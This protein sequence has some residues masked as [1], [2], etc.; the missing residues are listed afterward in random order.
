[1]QTQKYAVNQYLIESVLAKVRENE[2]AIPEIQRPFVW[3]ASQVRD[4]LDSLYQGYPV[5]YLIAWR[6]PDVQLKDGSTAS[7]KMILIDGQ[8]RVTALTAAILGQQVVNKEYRK[9]H[10]SIAFHPVEERFEV[11]NPAI[12]KNSAWIPDIAPIVGGKVTLIGAFNQYLQANPDV[13][14]QRLEAALTNL[15]NIAKKQIGLIELSH[16]LDIE[17][18]TEIFIRINSKGTVLSQAD[19]VMSKIAAD[20][21]YG[22]QE[23]RKCIDYFCH[24]AIA[25]EFY[26]QIKE[27]DTEFAE[28]TY[29]QKMAWLRNENDN[30]YDPTYNDLL[31]VAFTKEFERGKLPDLVS[32]L[33]GRNFETKVFEESIAEASFAKLTAG[34]LDFI[35]ESNFKRFVM[36]IKSSGFIDGNMIRT[37]GALNFAY[38]VY[39]RLRAQGVQDGKIESLVRRWFIMS[40]L[41]GRYSGSA[42]TQFDKD[43][44]QI[45][46]GDFAEILAKV[47]QAELSPAFWEFGLVQQLETSGTSSPYFWVF[48]AA[49]IRANDKG[50]LSK[51]ISVRE[52][53][54]HLGDIHHIFP[55]DLLKKSGLS[56]SQYNQIANYAYTQE[57]INIKIGNKAPL[58]YFAD[59]QNQCDGGPVKYGAIADMGTLKCNLIANCVPEAIFGMDVSAYEDF[60]KLRRQLMAEKIR[61]YYENL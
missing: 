35:N 31:R 45:A 49:Q 29:F 40:V 51:D 57:E 47:E 23:L 32:L 46:S 12:T 24:M 52:L 15:T 20:Q 50:L 42:E 19:F 59:I 4:L 8:Q 48:V 38:I 34:V 16:D 25:P 55:R 21:K 9:V 5:G 30:L 17:T 1:M 27:A 53:V 13:D 41:T 10:I 61:S 37:Q 26:G 3:D 36:I 60:L 44:R 11:S 54:S 22:G 39:L 7:G 58:I 43:I 56:R 6:N 28:S 14:Q 2:I 18:V 33:S